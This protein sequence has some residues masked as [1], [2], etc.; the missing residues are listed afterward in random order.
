MTFVS[1]AK[2]DIY[3]NYESAHRFFYKKDIN[4]SIV[5]FIFA[6]IF[7][8]VFL[9][10]T[11]NM[12]ENNYLFVSY[13]F[14]MISNT[15]GISLLSLGVWYLLDASNVEFMKIPIKV[16]IISLIPNLIQL[17]FCIAK[18]SNI[19]LMLISGFIALVISAILN[20]IYI[21]WEL[22]HEK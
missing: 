16:V 5:C 22:K 4:K 15:M 12:N 18:D 1:T 9:D 19:K 6:F 3:H 10:M 21:I 11:F 20:I 8:F 2:S 14:N 7:Y 17:A 13:L